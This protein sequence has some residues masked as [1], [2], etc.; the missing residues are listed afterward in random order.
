[1]KPR[2]VARVI[3]AML[4]LLTGYG[5]GRASTGGGVAAQ[6]ESTRVFELRTYTTPE[7]KLDQ[8]NAR[9]RDHTRRIFDRH[10]MTSI[11]YWTPVET[12]NTLVYILAHSSIDEAKKNWD[13]FRADPEWQKVKAETEAKGLTGIKVESRFLKPTDYSAIK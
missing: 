5:F 1:M 8:L 6:Q 12:P 9:F 10:N 13:A 2:S 3:A 7:G 11:G 4:L